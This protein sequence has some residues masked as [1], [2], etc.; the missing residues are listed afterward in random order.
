MPEL[1]GSQ[2]DGQRILAELKS[3]GQLENT[4]IFFFSNPARLAIVGTGCLVLL[5]WI[6][7]SF[8]WD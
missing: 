4:I 2:T 8:T 3:H 1:L 7:L 6:A 5:S